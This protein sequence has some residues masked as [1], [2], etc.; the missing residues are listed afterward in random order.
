MNRASL[1]T[2]V[3]VLGAGA[4]L[5]FSLAGEARNAP[6]GGQEQASAHSELQRTKVAEG[7]Y[8][9]IK[10]T[11]FGAVGPFGE[12]IYNFRETWTMWRSASGDYDVEGSRRF[13]S[14]ENTPHDDRFV[15]HLSRDMTVIDMTEFARLRWRLNSGPLSCQFLARELHCFAGGTGAKDIDLHTPME[16]PFGLFWPVSAFSLSGITREVEREPHRTAE[17]QLATIEQPSSDDPVEVT[18]LDSG[19]RYLG[20]QNIKLADTSWRAYKYSLHPALGPALMLQVSSK[21][22]LLSLSVLGPDK[23]VSGEEMRLIRFHQ[24]A[25]F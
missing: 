23:G 11:D 7:E 12:E 6:R 13:R 20:E 22:L 24:W 4:V 18:V 25:A 8:T 15:V 14:P 9:I 3:V 10:R 17:V 19:L 16:Q 2:P 5:F 21:G 1:F